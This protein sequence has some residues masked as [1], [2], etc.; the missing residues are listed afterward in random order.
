MCIGAP[1]RGERTAK[2]Q[3]VL[4][5]SSYEMKVPYP[6]INDKHIDPRFK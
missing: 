6:D 1:W 2:Y 5:N 4:D 3:E